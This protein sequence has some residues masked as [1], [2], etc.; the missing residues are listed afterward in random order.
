VLVPLLRRSA[1]RTPPRQP[2]APDGRAPL[3]PIGP[4]SQMQRDVVGR[5]ECSRAD[6]TSI[7][8]LARHSRRA[9]ARFLRPAAG[10]HSPNMSG[11]LQSRRESH[12]SIGAQGASGN[13]LRRGLHPPCRHTTDR[14]RREPHEQPRTAAQWCLSCVH[15]QTRFSCEKLRNNLADRPACSRKRRFRPQQFAQRNC[16][17]SGLLSLHHPKRLAALSTAMAFPQTG[18][19]FLALHKKLRHA[20][21]AEGVELQSD[22]V[23]YA[24]GV[25]NLPAVSRP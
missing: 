25:Y 9:S 22:H 24:V 7:H 6:W 21:L 23:A 18:R 14:R 19:R 11:T 10:R 5:S 16:V 1:Q 2:S 20:L 3:G 13:V 8:F 12:F 17:S 15:A 4:L